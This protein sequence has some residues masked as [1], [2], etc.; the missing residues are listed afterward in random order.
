MPANSIS[1][2]LDAIAYEWLA[3]N[4]PQLVEAIDALCT[5]ATA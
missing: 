4:Y 5:Q 1:T 2:I 3:T